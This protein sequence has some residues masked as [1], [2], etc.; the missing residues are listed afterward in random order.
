MKKVYYDVCEGNECAAIFSSKIKAVPAGTTLYP[1]SARDKNSEYQRYADVYDLKFI[2]DDDIP[3]I[4][5]YTVPQVDIF[6][7]DSVGG[8]FGTVGQITDIHDVAPICYINSSLESFS[9][10]NSLKIFLQMLA[11][12]CDWKT[13][14]S[15]IM[16][17]YFSNQEQKQSV[18]LNLQIYVGVRMVIA[19]PT[20]RTN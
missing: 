8:L 12:G 18:V 2:F 13:T 16:K 6:A 19:N 4:S 11:S 7:K 10:A 1:M 20:L 9:V 3:Q 14:C 5:F 17:L 15:L